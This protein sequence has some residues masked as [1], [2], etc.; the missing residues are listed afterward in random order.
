MRRVLFVFI[1]LFLSLQVFAEPVNIAIIKRGKEASWTGEMA[2]YYDQLKS[3]IKN[4]KYFKLN[5]GI[6]PDKDFKIPF[7]IDFAQIISPVNLFEYHNEK[8]LDLMLFVN[9]ESNYF[10]M[11][12][13]EFPSGIVLNE[14]KIGMQNLKA[15]SVISNITSQISIYENLVSNKWQQYGVP[16]ENTDFGI[17]L[18]TDDSKNILLAKSLDVINNTFFDN[19][20]AYWN[21]SLKYKMISSKEQSIMD[22]AK[23]ANQ[24]SA[25]FALDFSKKKNEPVTMVFPY[26]DPNTPALHVDYPY[27]PIIESFFS[28]QQSADQFDPNTFCSIVLNDNGALTQL[29]LTKTNLPLFINRTLVMHR[30]WTSGLITIDVFKQQLYDN[31]NMIY[32][33]LEAASPLKPWIGLN[34]AAFCRTIY[35]FDQSLQMLD[36]ARAS[37]RALNNQFGENLCRIEEAK[38]AGLQQEWSTVEKIYQDLLNQKS[39]PV[40]SASVAEIHYNLGLLYEIKNDLS[41][42]ILH[43]EKSVKLYAYLKDTFRAMLPQSKLC[44]IYRQVNAL[45]KSETAAKRYLA[46][47][48]GLQSE[49]DIARARYELGL[50][51]LALNNLQTAKNDFIIA[52]NYFEML[53][54]KLY[55]AYIDLNLG[56]ITLKNKQYVDAN[57]FLQKALQNGRQLKNY[58]LMIDSYRYLGELE[59][60][61]QNWNAAQKYFENGVNTALELNNTEKLAEVLYQQGLAHIKEGKLSIGF[62]EVKK[63]IE[64]SNGKVHGGPKQAQAFIKKLEQVIADKRQEAGF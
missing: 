24:Y 17:L 27:I 58:P 55:T 22:M 34:F 39:P 43:H 62:V 12:L 36:Y 26:S 56:V 38:Q 63:G 11:Y 30:N 28:F 7:S 5:D 15:S 60:Q 61:L 14:K 23:I 32:R 52:K 64:L 48:N 45:D 19:K 47:A 40:D 29:E 2:A 8:N 33:S 31:Y 18:L 13:L 4:S 3:G 21:G 6:D 25:R 9:A 49:P 1:I 10:S 51:H 20:S 42:A 57:P 44:Y 46:M 54:D 35:S 50:V 41:L 37:F 53:D 59:A 16:F